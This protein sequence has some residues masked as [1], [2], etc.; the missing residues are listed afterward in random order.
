MCT[1]K[2][3]GYQRRHVFIWSVSFSPNNFMIVSLIKREW[4]NNSFP[5]MFA[6]AHIISDAGT[7]HCRYTGSK[8]DAAADLDLFSAHLK[9]VTAYLIF[10]MPQMFPTSNLKFRNLVNHISIFITTKNYNYYYNLVYSFLI[11]LF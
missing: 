4:N 10:C 8:I 11:T 6:R 7:I 5:I 3:C 1:T 2:I 9:I